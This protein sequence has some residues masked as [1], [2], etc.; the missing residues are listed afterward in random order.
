MTISSDKLGTIRKL[1][2]KAQ[3]TTNPHEAAIFMAKAQSMMEDEGV[4]MHAV[5]LSAIG[6]ARVKSLFS[7]SKPTQHE[8]TLM[9]AVCD[10]FGCKLLWQGRHTTYKAECL[11]GTTRSFRYKGDTYG[12]FVF[13]GP[14][15]RLNL[16]TY[17]AE[18][19]GRQLRKAR[20]DFVEQRTEHYLDAACQDFESEDHEDIRND[21][22]IRNAIRKHVTNE[23]YSFAAGW[24]YEIRKKVVRFALNDKEQELIESFTAGVP[25]GEV[26]KKELGADFYRGRAAAKDASLHRPLDEAG[27]SVKLLGDA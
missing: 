6:E 25:E 9:Q 16:A 17:A 8:A 3:G 14:K 27:V 2:A 1:M 19:L 22:R 10:A 12:R 13:V 18:V 20:A 23:A 7:A 24:A 5:D 26:K 4:D 15:D 21:N 11:D